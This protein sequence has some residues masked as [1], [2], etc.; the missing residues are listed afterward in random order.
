MLGAQKKGAMLPW[1]LQKVLAIP[2]AVLEPERRCR[3][4]GIRMRALPA[5]DETRTMRRTHAFEI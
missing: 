1:R 3:N 5:A 2:R 4:T